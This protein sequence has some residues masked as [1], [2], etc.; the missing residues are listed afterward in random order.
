VGDF[1]PYHPL[2]LRLGLGLAFLVALALTGWAVLEFVG[3]HTPRDILRA[4]LSGGLAA[5]MGLTLFRLRPRAGWGVQ[6]TPL[7]VLVS[8][9][10]GGLIEIPWDAVKDV[11]RLG[12]KRDTLA[13]WLGERDRV[14]VPAHLFARRAT[15]EALAQRIDERRPV[16]S[17]SGH[18]VH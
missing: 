14:L 6:V 1:F 4:G 10:R 9:P 18:A 3:T 8:R 7:S 5:A 13:L 17:H 15:F 12:D 16:A 2:K 11:R